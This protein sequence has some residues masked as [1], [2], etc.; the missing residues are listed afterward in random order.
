MSS[1]IEANSEI[2]ARQQARDAIEAERRRMAEKGNTAASARYFSRHKDDVLK[3]RIEYRIAAGSI[4]TSVSMERYGITIDSVNAIRRISGLPPLK[5]D[6]Y[7]LRLTDEDMSPSL[8]AEVSRRMADE[9]KMRELN[10]AKQ[11]AEK[12][13]LERQQAEAA[14]SDA[15]DILATDRNLV[16][17]D[18]TFKTSIEDVKAYFLTPD[19]RTGELP[20]IRDSRGGDLAKRTRESTIKATLHTLQQAM[21]CDTSRDIVDCMKN[22]EKVKTFFAAQYKKNQDSGGKFGV[23]LSAKTILSRIQRMYALN[24]YY[25]LNFTRGT[26][27]PPL[28]P[29]D[30]VDKYSALSRFYQGLADKKTEQQVKTDVVYPFSKI[31]EMVQKKFPKT[32]DSYPWQN[33]IIRLYDYKTVRD[34]YSELLIVNSKDKITDKKDKGYIV[35]PPKNG[36]VYI[37]VNSHKTV[38]RYGK[39]KVELDAALTKEVRFYMKANDLSYG[40]YLFHKKNRKREFYKNGLTS[41]I[42]KML[43]EAG[44]KDTDDADNNQNINLFRHAKV[45]EVAPNATEEE[46]IELAEK[47]NHMTTTQTQ[48]VR[49]MAKQ[50][51]QADK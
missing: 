36:L 1:V 30:I 13:V 9:T 18:G 31:M 8:N 40:D 4:P 43:R 49:Q 10:E 24:Y 46:K 32:A 42:G 6:V 37:Q 17:A 45:S 47:M 38:K 14:T 34:N 16:N 44:V 51:L 12:I 48:Y 25:L 22:F 26:N 28:L 5:A 11:R 7:P 41:V 23:G 2:V 21:N 29:D 27:K 15:A 33:L 19:P 20:I 39:I 3:R 35:V 50:F